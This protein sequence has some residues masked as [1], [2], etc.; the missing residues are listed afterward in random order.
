VAVEML[1][2]QVF[3]AQ[4]ILEEAEE[5]LEITLELEVMEALVL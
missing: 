5:V 4:Q 2:I 3:Q 1:V